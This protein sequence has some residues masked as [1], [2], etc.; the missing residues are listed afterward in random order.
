MELAVVKYIKQYGLDKTLNDFNLKSRDY[1]HKVIIKYDQIASLMSA[2]EVQDSRGLVL[3]KDTWRVMSMS[4]RKFFNAAEGHAANIDW[5]TASILEKLDGSLIHMYWDWVLEKWCIGTTGT[6]DASGEVNNKEGTTF[7]DLFWRTVGDKYGLTPD[8]KVLDKGF[9]Y[10]FELC[11]PYNIVVNPHAVPSATLLTMRNVSTLKEVTYHQMTLEANEMNMPFVTAYDLNA[12]NVGH[13]IKTFESMPYIDEGY[14]IV[15]GNHNR[16][17]LKNPAYVAVHHLKSKTAEY[18]IVEIVKTNEIDEFGATFPERKDE[19]IKLK[20]NFDTLSLT[21]N[22]AWTHLC[23][24]K[25]KTMEKKYQKA[26]AMKVFEVAKDRGLEN[27][28]G[29]F[30]GLKDYK[31]PSVEDYIMT[32]D[33]KK[34]YALL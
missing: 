4:F 31:I 32:M 17:K 28:T 8:S 2:P 33:N 23:A 21:L 24:H 13:L 3:E 7:E 14:V 30:F 19:I 34:L 20:A 16:I 9:T 1:G 15:D 25:P 27:H 10:V 11:T 18:N 6:A 22:E 26:F 12:T 5:A 29:L